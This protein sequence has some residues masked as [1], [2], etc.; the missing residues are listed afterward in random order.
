MVKRE[1]NCV[2]NSTSKVRLRRDKL[3]LHGKAFVFYNCHQICIGTTTI[4]QIRSTICISLG[5]HSPLTL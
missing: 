1:E 5:D 2:G 3:K 4:V